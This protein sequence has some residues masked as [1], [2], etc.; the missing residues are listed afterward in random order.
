MAVPSTLPPS[1][2]EKKKAWKFRDSAAVV[3]QSTVS[4]VTNMGYSD[5]NQGHGSAA[6]YLSEDPG[7]SQYSS[8]YGH[9][10]QAQQTYPR[11]SRDSRGGGGG[12]QIASGVDESIP[13]SHVK[14][15]SR[16][17]YLGGLPDSVTRE[18]VIAA[19]DSMENVYV[20]LSFYQS[21]PLYY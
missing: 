6:T 12:G 21:A 17:L 4:S 5:V 9:G 1:S 7:G 15:L 10:S 20:R 11:E 13:I 14:V 18:Q 8:S 16:T 3:D 19:F 2:T